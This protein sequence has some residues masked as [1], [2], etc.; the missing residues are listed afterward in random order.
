MRMKPLLRL[1]AFFL[2]LLLLPTL[3]C[4]TLHNC[5]H[6]DEPDAVEAEKQVLRETLRAERPDTLPAG[7]PSLKVIVIDVGQGDSI[8]LISP[9]G[10]TMLVDAGPK[11]SFSRIKNVLDAN[12][13][14]SLDI[15]V[16]THPHEDHIGSMA[17]VLDAY[18]VGQFLTIPQAE[19]NDSYPL[20]CSALER[21]GCPV[22]YAQGGTT[23]PWAHSCTVTVLN[24]LLSY[25]EP[26]DFNDLSVVLHVRCGD[27]AVLLTGDAGEQAEKRM[28]D[29]FP[30]SMLKANVLK[31]GHHG[32]SSAT[33]F[34]F[35][36]AVDA[37][38]A[39]ASCG[40][41][42]DFGHPHLETLSLLHDTRTAFYSTDLDGTVTFCLDGETVSVDL[43]RK[44]N[45]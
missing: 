19:T 3:G 8:L 42:N 13:V 4:T 24:P 38:F 16:A 21:N 34:S 41:N 9:E 35:F 17:K 39:V 10:R 11:G 14:R 37:D 40:T 32:S 43:S 31:L 6:A 15:V 7:E 23:I 30:R 26:R 20:M 2:A 25:A 18:P 36:L 45:P 12:D 27:T 1:L 5:L 22:A 29:T 44:E 28:L 33:G